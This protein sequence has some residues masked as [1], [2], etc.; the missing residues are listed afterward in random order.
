[1]IAPVQVTV[2][3]VPVLVYPVLQVHTT[4]FVDVS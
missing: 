1:M 3:L 4:A 2:G